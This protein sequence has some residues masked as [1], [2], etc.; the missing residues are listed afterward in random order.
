VQDEIEFAAVE[1]YS[2]RRDSGARRNLISGGR[3]LDHARSCEF[4]NDSDPEAAII[5]EY[6]QYR[7]ISD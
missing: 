4:P 5:T 1:P 2:R 3:L 6:S 7:R